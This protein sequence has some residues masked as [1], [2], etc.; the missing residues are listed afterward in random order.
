MGKFELTEF[1]AATAPAPLCW[2]EI[3][4]IE[5]LWEEEAVI[6]QLFTH[7]F[8]CHW[9]EWEWQKMAKMSTDQNL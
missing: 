4:Q 5:L 9:E 1:N 2:P 8:E 3:G 7:I 6:K